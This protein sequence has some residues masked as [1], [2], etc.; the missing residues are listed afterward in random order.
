MYKNILVAIDGSAASDAA[1][2]EALA[3]A[4][5]VRAELQLVHVAQV[6]PP[7][8]LVAPSIGAA[9]DLEMYSDSIEEAGR[10][11]LESA[12]QHA[13]AAR[14]TATTLL[15]RD[16]GRD[17]SRTILSAAKRTRA[18]LIAMGTHGRTGL[19]RL[20]MGS[21]T[22]G[23]ARESPVP[24]LLVKAK[25]RGQSGRAATRG[26]FARGRTAADGSRRTGG[27]GASHRA[28]RSPASPP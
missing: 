24:M 23:V 10:G 11:I 2:G 17:A 15:L 3:L 22:E 19:A 4:K 7:P 21:V 12:L 27:R 14:V 5:A 18:D 28:P 9:W 16:V 25:R 13:R 8:G 26:A 20:L 6:V 1:L